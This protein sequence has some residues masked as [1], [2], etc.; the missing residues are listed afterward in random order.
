MKRLDDP[1][2]DVLPP[3]AAGHLERDS[4]HQIYWEDSGAL[5]GI[6]LVLC[7]GGP[8]GSNQPGYRRTCDP[9]RFRI[10]QFDQRGCGQSTPKGELNANSLQITLGDMEA[11][12]EHLGVDRWMVAGGSWGATVALAYGEAH[13]ERCLAVGLISLWLCRKQ[14]MDW[15]FQGVRTVFPELWHEFSRHVPEAE[16]QDMRAA[17]CSRILGDD[18]EIADAFARR[19]FLYEEGFMRFATPIVPPDP[20]NAAYGRIFAHYAHNDF[21]LREN[22]LIE[23]AG[24]LS[25]VPVSLVTGRYDMCTTPNNAFDLSQALPHAQLTITPGAGHYPTEER[26]SLACLEVLE[27]LADQVEQ[28]G[29]SS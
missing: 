21:F 11:L 20:T 12:R 4:G 8:G 7:H 5:D 16:R 29:L 1:Y 26:L 25:D 27:S 17:Y 2:Y 22:Q 15:W 13:P 18:R 14:D 3:R 6:P 23:E 24:R 19:L 28:R 10:I 9:D